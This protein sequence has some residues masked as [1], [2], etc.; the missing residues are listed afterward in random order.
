VEGKAASTHYCLSKRRKQV[1]NSSEPLIIE[2]DEQLTAF[3]LQ[4]IALWEERCSADHDTLI[5]AW[6]K[7]EKRIANE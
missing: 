3:L 7:L 4:V 5:S 2:N 1:V 6:E